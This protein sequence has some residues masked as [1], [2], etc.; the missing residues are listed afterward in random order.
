MAVVFKLK[1]TLTVTLLV[2]LLLITSIKV[3]LAMMRKFLDQSCALFVK[4]LSV[5]QLNSLTRI[6]GVTVLQSL[7]RMVTLLAS[8]NLRLKQVKSVLTYQSQCH[9]LCSH[10]PVTKPACGVL[11]TSMAK[12]LSNSIHNGRQ[13]LLAGRKNQQKP[14]NW[15]QI[16]QL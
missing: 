8:S 5:K 2:Q 4:T 1:T 12:V 7:P 10:L 3:W 14:K 15:L 13:S 6:N 11:L 9:Y 16:S